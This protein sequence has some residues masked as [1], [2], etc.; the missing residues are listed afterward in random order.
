MI[1]F[2]QNIVPREPA[3]YDK[4]NSLEKHSLWFKYKV[5][6]WLANDSPQTVVVHNIMRVLRAIHSQ[7]LAYISVPITSGRFLYLLKLEKPSTPPDTLLTEAIY[8][9]YLLGLH[10]EEELKERVS[11][12][13]LYPADL[14]PVHQEWEQAHFQALWLSIIAEK[15]TE[16]HMCEDWEYSNGGSEE[17]VHAMQLKLGIPRHRD[18]AFWNTKEGEAASRERMRNIKI[19]NHEGTELTLDYGIRAI[20]RSLA[21]IKEKGF[22]AKKLEVSLQL[23]RWTEG[24]LAKGF[25]Q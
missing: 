2:S 1:V 17:F 4:E 8:H 14:V 16:L 11:F 18:L 6:V 7:E 12:P 25:Y 9:N 24:M 22:E 10:F 21:W 23:L 20:E 3:M 13:I 15:C 19:F 5:P